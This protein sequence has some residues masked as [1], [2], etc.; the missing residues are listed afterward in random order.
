MRL[1]W[2]MYKPVPEAVD[3]LVGQSGGNRYDLE[4]CFN[5]LI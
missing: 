2:L 3:G 1:T 5:K 4:Q